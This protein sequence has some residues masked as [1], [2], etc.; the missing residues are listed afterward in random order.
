MFDSETA[1][2][3]GL[4]QCCAGDND[5]I[6]IGEGSNI[7]DGSI[8]HTDDGVPLTIGSN[9]TVGHMVMLHG[10]TIG[11]G[12][13]IG[14]NAVVL[15]KAVIGKNCIIGANTL[16]P[17]G[18]VIPDRSLVVGSPGRIIRQLT[19]DDLQRL[20]E[21][22]DGYVGNARRYAAELVDI[23]CQGLKPRADG[24]AAVH[25]AAGRFMPTAAPPRA[26]ARTTTAQ[27]MTAPPSNCTGSIASPRNSAARTMVTT[28]SSVDKVAASA[29]PNR[30][31]P[32]KHTIPATLHS[33]AINTIASQAGPVAGKRA[34]AV[35][36]MAPKLAPAASITIV[37]AARD[38]PARAP[39]CRPEYR[40]SR[41]PLRQ[42]PSRMPSGCPLTSP[43][44]V[45]AVPSR[46][47]RTAPTLSAPRR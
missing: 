45:S 19:D 38:P 41:A 35:N 32:A 3:S 23:T 26:R 4:A 12:S 29:G 24:D 37:A 18:K 22:A 17:E 27:R 10:C 7:Q 11:D 6:T 1:P 40:S 46:A 36:T 8:L 21:N 13:L 44:M 39:G 14:I 25:P 2:T 28:G 31:M 20:M 42:T 47:A 33:N 5:P 9:V 15:N 43:P 16:I 34:P 30:C